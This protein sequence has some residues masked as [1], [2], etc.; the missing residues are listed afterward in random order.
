[1]KKKIILILMLIIT[2]GLIV[3]CGSG[4][5]LNPEENNNNQ[6][7]DDNKKVS[8]FDDDY[9]I[10]NYYISHIHT[11][12][13]YT[14]TEVG[15]TDASK[16][17]FSYTQ[18]INSEVSKEGNKYSFVDET[19]SSLVNNKHEA[20]FED[21]NVK[22]KN[23]SDKEFIEVSLSDYKNKYGVAPSDVC[24][25][26]A[27]FKKEGIKEINHTYDEETKEYTFNIAL[28]GEIV[29]TNM[30]I[31]AKEFGSLQDYPKYQSLNVTLVIKDN[32][33]PVKATITS[34]YTISVFLLGEMNCKQVLNEVFS[35]IKLNEDNDGKDRK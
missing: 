28:D 2:T 13:S 12:Y 33:E 6:N 19:S 15:Q 29:A 31:Q 4:E 32:F 26:G 11:Y 35:N 5:I 10:I 9:E 1:M 18:K 14:I 22:Y 34:E 17:G 21:D 27:S 8:D 23:S 25:F 3:S 16:G 24:L 20:Y 30:K 7:V